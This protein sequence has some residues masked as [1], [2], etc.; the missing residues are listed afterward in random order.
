MH[1]TFG[2]I[3]SS[4]LVLNNFVKEWRFGRSYEK[5]TGSKFKKHIADYETN[6]EKS[7]L[8][9]IL[10]QRSKKTKVVISAEILNKSCEW[11]FSNTDAKFVLWSLISQTS[12][13]S[14]ENSKRDWQFVPW[15]N[16]SLWHYITQIPLN[17]LPMLDCSSSLI[18]TSSI[19]SVVSS[20]TFIKCFLT[21]K[22]E[23]IFRRRY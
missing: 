23:S 7:M 14:S 16:S 18:S 19:L 8:S 2:T 12:R 17:L 15:T 6:R 20:L 21:I 3:F 5:E 4:I 10:C 22:Y 11:I 9:S 1:R 13:F